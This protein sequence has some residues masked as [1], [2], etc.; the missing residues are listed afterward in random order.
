MPWTE[1]AS[2]ST[3]IEIKPLS[4]WVLSLLK[5]VSLSG[6]FSIGKYLNISNS[7]IAE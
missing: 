2:G 3:L 7:S 5:S 4:G 1:R 6:L